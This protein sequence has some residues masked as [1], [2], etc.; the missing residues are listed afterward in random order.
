ML[1]KTTFF[2][3]CIY[4]QKITC[5][6]F[7]ILFGLYSI[8]SPFSHQSCTSSTLLLPKEIYTRKSKTN[9][10]QFIFFVFLNISKGIYKKFIRKHYTQKSFIHNELFCK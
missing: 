5:I 10:R 6:I 2:V 7:F 9:L 8:A 4:L 3:K 1:F